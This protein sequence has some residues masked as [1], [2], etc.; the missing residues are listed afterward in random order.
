MKGGITH[1][2][3]QTC[4]RCRQLYAWTP[5]LGLCPYCDLS[6]RARQTEPYDHG[7]PCPDDCCPTRERTNA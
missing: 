5:A 2:E 3:I 1:R 7:E 4:P 6:Q